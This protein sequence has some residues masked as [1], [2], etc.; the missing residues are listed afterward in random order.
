MRL[1]HGTQVGTLLLQENLSLPHQL[2]HKKKLNP[3]GAST[4]AINQ[5][6]VNVTN[7]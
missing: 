1:P 3:Y 7:V 4:T 2:K 6:S 5:I